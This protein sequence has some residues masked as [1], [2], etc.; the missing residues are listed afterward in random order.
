[1]KN[2]KK[3][4]LLLLCFTLIITVFALSPQSDCHDCLGEG[5][6]MCTLLNGTEILC[7]RQ[8][9]TAFLLCALS[10]VIMLLSVP[11]KR[12]IFESHDTLIKLK[13][14]LSA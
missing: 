2:G 1:M 13:V 14:K 4:I 6:L 3:I 12:L 8:I 5:C 11:S 9:N 10:A 7:F